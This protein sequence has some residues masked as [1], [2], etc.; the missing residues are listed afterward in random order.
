[1]GSQKGQAQDR[2]DVGGELERE[3]IQE[4]PELPAS[5]WPDIAELLSSGLAHSEDLWLSGFEHILFG[6]Y[7]LRV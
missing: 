7:N 2:S 5:S 4:S 1:M 6:F 3:L